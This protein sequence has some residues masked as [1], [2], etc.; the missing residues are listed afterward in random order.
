MPIL[1]YGATVNP[2]PRDDAATPA[3][4]AVTLG[5]IVG[6]KLPSPDGQ[7]LKGALR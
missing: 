1:F 7:V 2:G 3:D 4:V 6:V 5:A